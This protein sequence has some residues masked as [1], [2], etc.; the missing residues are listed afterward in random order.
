METHHLHL[1]QELATAASFMMS[2]SKLSDGKASENIAQ[3]AQPVRADGEAV[4]QDI[5][6]GRVRA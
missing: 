2:I 4:R 1:P 6:S 5:G 3:D